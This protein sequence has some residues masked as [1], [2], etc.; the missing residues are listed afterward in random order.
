MK[1]PTWIKSFV[2]LIILLVGFAPVLIYLWISTRTPILTVESG[3]AVLND[4]G[5][6]AI[7]VD[8]RSREE[9]SAVHIAGSLNWPAAEIASL[10]SSLQIP[11][12]FQGRPLLLICNSGFQSALSGEKLRS[13]GVNDVYYIRGGLQSWIGISNSSSPYAKVVFPS[14]GTSIH[15]PMTLFEQTAAV[16]SGFGFKPLHMMLSAVL[17]IVLLR[18]RAADLRLFGWG[19]VIFLAAETFCAINYLFYNHNSYLAEYLHSY[20]MALSF[21]FTAFALMLGTD[22]RLLKLSA[23]DKRCLFLPL[24]RGCAKYNQGSCKMRTLLQLLTV[25]LAILAFI[26]LLTAP[27]QTSYLSDIFGTTYHYCRLLL[28]QYFEGRY[29][30]LVSIVFCLGALLTMQKQKEE[31][32]PQLAMMF[33]AGALAALGF[34]MF[35]LTLGAIFDNALIWADFWEE[36]TE[37]MFVAF[38][39]IVLWIYKDGLLDVPIN[40]NIFSKHLPSVKI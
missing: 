10:D 4:P 33:L 1:Y 32:A 6:N 24:C 26:P 19:I 13:L 40:K 18:Q 7:L 14:A 38:A 39:A 30:P 20:G 36:V 2:T 17:G 12:D 9:F 27:I 5:Q 22:D 16:V 31:S 23:S 35:R 8:V 25:A 34:S 3:L 37:L 28:S 21:G 15:R 29:L 11:A